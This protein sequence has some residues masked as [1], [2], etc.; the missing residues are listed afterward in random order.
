MYVEENLN[1]NNSRVGDCVIRAISKLL[2]QSW[3][4]TYIDLC[5]LGM[6]MKDLPS[7]NVVWSTYLHDN[8]FHRCSIPDTCPDCY[9]I[10]DFCRDFPLGRYL[11][12]TGSHVV[13][14]IDGQY[15]DTWR[16]GSEI[17]I[18]YFFRES[19]V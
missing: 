15:Y 1:P 12:A 8:G 2:N 17:P 5:V 4:R 14:V 7:A 18:F 11:V 13:A 9:T 6:Q 19:E 10:R 16:S 3:E